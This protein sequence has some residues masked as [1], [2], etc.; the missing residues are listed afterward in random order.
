MEVNIQSQKE[1]FS[2]NYFIKLNLIGGGPH[3]QMIERL[4]RMKD[5]CG[6]PKVKIADCH[7][8]YQDVEA[9]AHDLMTWEGELYMEGHQ[10]TYTSIAKVKK[11]NRLS[12]IY[13]RDAEIFAT[14]NHIS[15]QLLGTTAK[16]NWSTIHKLWEKLLLDQFHDVLPG[17]SIGL[18]Y[19]QTDKD[20]EEI[21]TETYRLGKENFAELIPAIFNVKTLTEG[22]VNAYA[23]IN[24]TQYDRTNIFDIQGKQYRIYLTDLGIEL[25]PKHLIVN[26]EE[27]YLS[28]EEDL[29][30]SHYVVTNK[31]Y[32]IQIGF[33][34]QIESILDKR[35]KK[36]NLESTMKES[37]DK[38][39]ENY[40]KGNMF[41]MHEDLPIFW[42]AWDIWIYYMDTR[43]DFSA[44]THS[45]HLTEK[46]SL[47]LKFTYNIPGSGKS[48]MIQDI[49]IGN[50]DER[51][52]FKTTIN[53]DEMHKCL[54][55][56]F[57]LSNI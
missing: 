39:N 36:F 41:S 1:F 7:E 50:S 12:E 2:I 43:K 49:V 38:N 29:A 34:G 33:N 46:V 54:R 31:F 13:L 6:L 37:I 5:I 8:F 19:D 23:F 44:S 3:D 21:Q 53:W 16:D 14:F 22:D 17:A 56:Y 27:N 57:P 35:T 51:I 9:N 52:D 20:Y 45:H 28:I 55:V 25:I 24:T 32:I 11:G 42:D 4:D 10:G 15:H 30:E 40:S 18:I 26:T 48:T 47:I